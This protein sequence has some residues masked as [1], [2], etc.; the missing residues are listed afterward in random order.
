[1]NLKNEGNEI[2]SLIKSFLDNYQKPQEVFSEEEAA[3]YL[4]VP[5]R[6]LKNYSKKKKITWSLIGKQKIYTRKNLLDFIDR[7]SRLYKN[8]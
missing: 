5:L 4:R 6:T 7:K 8:W 2:L 1:M 3:D